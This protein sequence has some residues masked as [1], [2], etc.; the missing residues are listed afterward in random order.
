MRLLVHHHRLLNESDGF[1]IKAQLDV[2]LRFRQP[3][4]VNT[5]LTVKV[6]TD[7]KLSDR[8]GFEERL[9]KKRRAWVAY[10]VQAFTERDPINQ[11]RETTFR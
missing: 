1:P 6:E 2:R 9:P 7:S 8:D 10:L 11:H 5:P 3:A 4:H